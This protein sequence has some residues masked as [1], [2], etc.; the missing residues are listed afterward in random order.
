MSGR[1]KSPVYKSKNNMTEPLVINIKYHKIDSVK[2]TIFTKL[3]SNTSQKKAGY[4]T[5]NRYFKQP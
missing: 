3:E 5:Q 4:N 1:T 2:S